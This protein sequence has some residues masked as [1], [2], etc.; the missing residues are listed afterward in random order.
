MFNDS[1]VHVKYKVTSVWHCLI[2][3][4]ESI[5]TSRY[6][7]H[8]I[9]NLMVWLSDSCS[10]IPSSWT[11]III[12][13]SSPQDTRWSRLRSCQLSA[14]ADKLS[15]EIH[16]TEIQHTEIELIYLLWHIKYTLVR[17]IRLA[18]RTCSLMLVLSESA[19]CRVD[20]LVHSLVNVEKYVSQ[21]N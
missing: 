18:N 10:S 9:L 14:E 7:Q 8:N 21:N 13:V 19:W 12:K 16:H 17:R 2:V 5:K 3:I 11:K 1:L 15:T 20:D 4:N 6:Y